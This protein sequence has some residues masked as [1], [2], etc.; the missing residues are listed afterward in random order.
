MSD[1]SKISTAELQMELERRRE[2]EQK[3]RDA[4]LKS[5]EIIIRCPDC[6]GS[7]DKLV[8]EGYALVGSDRCIYCDGR[9]TITAYRA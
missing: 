7:G 1:L 9:G 3:L 8:Y 2:A 4:D 5:R 6:G